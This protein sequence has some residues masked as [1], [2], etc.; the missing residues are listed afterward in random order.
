M[1]RAGRP[2]VMPPR[3]KFPLL[4]AFTGGDYDAI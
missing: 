1:M 4:T 2:P 3:P